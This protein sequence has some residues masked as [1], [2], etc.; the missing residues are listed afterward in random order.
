MLET[1]GTESS[2]QCESRCEG[3]DRFWVITFTPL[4]LSGAFPGL[5]LKL[6][7]LCHA[8]RLPPPF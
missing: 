3:E 4:F 6:S 5:P 2:A 1:Q 8:V 7:S